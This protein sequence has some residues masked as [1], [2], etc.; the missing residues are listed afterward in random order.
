MT[1]YIP[2]RDMSPVETELDRNIYIGEGLESIDSLETFLAAA[3]TLRVTVSEAMQKREE[4]TETIAKY[5]TTLLIRAAQGYAR[6]VQTVDDSKE[7]YQYGAE[8]LQ[9]SFVEILKV[10]EKHGCNIVVSMSTTDEIAETLETEAEG[11]D[12]DKEFAMLEQ[13]FRNSHYEFIEMMLKDE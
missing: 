2:K 13:T 7:M 11:L 6:A 12:K 9:H 4:L 3:D 10:S 1:E 8:L 5:L